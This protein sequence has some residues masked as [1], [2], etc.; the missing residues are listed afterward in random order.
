MKRAQIGLIGFGTVGSGVYNLLTHNAGIIRERTGID[1]SLKTICD[2]RTDVVERLTQGVTVTG[3]W[4][5]VVQDP[6][7]DIV[8]EL[9]GG[10]EPAKTI[11]LEAM[12]R[13][14]S[15]ITANKKLLAEEGSEIFEA[16]MKGPV[17]LG[18]EASVGGGMPCIMALRYGLVGN[19]IRTVMGILNG[20]TNYILSRM[21]DDSLSFHDALKDAQQRGFA[22]ADPTFDIEGYDTGHKISLLSMLAFN[23]RIDYRRLTIEGITKIQRMDISYAA[24]MGYRIKLLGIAKAAGDSIDI[25]VHPT[26]LPYKHPLATVRDEFNAVLFDGDMTDPVILYGKG[27][28]SN[29]TASAVVSDVVQIVEK[30]NAESLTLPPAGA[31]TYLPPEERVSRYYLRIHTEDRP[32]ILSKISGILGDYEISISSVIQKEVDSLHVPLIIMTHASTE[33][34]MLRAV[35]DMKECSFV[36][37]DMMLIRVE[38]SQDHQGV[39]P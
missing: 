1:V 2:L 12:R 36:H 26:M 11:I 22:E 20:T 27:A 18:F 10:I 6:S 13:G 35:R 4:K 14:K 24:E 25:R 29:P 15:V 8:V 3:D 23:R 17:K 38:D 5:T 28:G 16:S 7:I 21:E 33:D 30:M 39:R 32:G 19:R 34:G 9:I 37:E 31:V